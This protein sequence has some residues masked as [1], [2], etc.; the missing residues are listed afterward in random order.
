MV[1]IVHSVTFKVH[2]DTQGQYMN[3]LLK[4]GPNMLE[5]L[6][7][8]NTLCLP[9]VSRMVDILTVSTLYKKLCGKLLLHFFQML[10]AFLHCI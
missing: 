8:L 7:C 5:L 10:E 1:N 2:H 9:V 6:S 3:D 4:N